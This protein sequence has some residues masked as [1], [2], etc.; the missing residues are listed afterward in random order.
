M[1]CD[2]RAF[3]ASLLDLQPVTQLLQPSLRRL[4]RA[5]FYSQNQLA[6]K[7]AEVAAKH[8]EFMSA[9]Q[10]HAQFEGALRDAESAHGETKEALKAQL[11]REEE[12]L[13]KLEH[14]AASAEASLKARAW[15]RRW[16]CVMRVTAPSC[17]VVAHARVE[18]WHDD[19]YAACERSLKARGA[20]HCGATMPV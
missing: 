15:K 9:T 20:S 13:S 7:H 14:E 6:T 3:V 8:D 2:A 18:P 10:K 17:G 16:L 19:G 5:L 12:L 1:R 11:A 4:H